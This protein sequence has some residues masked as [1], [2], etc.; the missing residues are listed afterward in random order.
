MMNEQEIAQV[1]RSLNLETDEDR[2]ALHFD[3]V[4]F[5]ESCPIQVITTDRTSYAVACEEGAEVA[6]A[7]RDSQ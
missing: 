1:F 2:R 3:S 5:E 7:E 4:N 6:Y